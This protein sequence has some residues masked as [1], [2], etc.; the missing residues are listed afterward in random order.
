LGPQGNV[1]RRIEKEF[2]VTLSVSS[3]SGDIEIDL[4]PGNDDV[5]ILWTVRNVIQA[6][7]RGFSPNRAITLINEENDLYIIDLVDYVG[8][9]KKAHSRVKGRVIGRNGKSRILLEELTDCF[10]CVYG[11]TIAII[12]PHEAL[13]SAKEA[14]LMLV[15]GAFHKT[16]WNHLYAY[17]RK[18]KKERGEL[19]YEPPKKRRNQWSK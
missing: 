19:W 7:G 1:K 9:G 15:K 11:G 6:I 4:S 13:P 8:T 5:S 14:I 16:V 2:N 3:D 12:G 17:R 18:M 10:I